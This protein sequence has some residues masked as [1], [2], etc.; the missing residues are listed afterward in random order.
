VETLAYVVVASSDTLERHV[1]NQ[2]EPFTHEEK[3]ALKRYHLDNPSF[4]ITNSSF[5]IT[6]ST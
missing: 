6:N 3:E 2:D 1:L 4:S 5:S